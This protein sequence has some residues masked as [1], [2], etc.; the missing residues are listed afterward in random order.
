MIDEILLSLFAGISATCAKKKKKLFFLYSPLW[1]FS[2]Q[3]RENGE[4]VHFLVLSLRPPLSILYSKEK[5]KLS[6]SAENY[7]LRKNKKRRDKAYKK[8]KETDGKGV[9]DLQE[10]RRVLGEVVYP[11]EKEEEGQEKRKKVVSLSPGKT[12]SCLS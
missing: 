1:P 6:F 5:Q 4:A 9:E 11:Q 7:P 2:K 3:T 10:R 8:G 12:I